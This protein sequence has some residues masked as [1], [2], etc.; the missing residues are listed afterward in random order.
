MHFSKPDYE[1][2]NCEA[3]FLPYKIGTKCPN[4][5]VSISDTD[6]EEYLD[7]IKGIAESMKVHKLGHGTYFPGAWSILSMMDHIQSIIF[8]LF[9]TLEHEKAKNEEEFLIDLL[10][11][12]FE[13]DGREYLKDHIKSITKEIFIIYK[14]KE[15]LKSEYVEQKNTDPV[16]ETKIEKFKKGWH[17]FCHKNET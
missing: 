13:W 9:D 1:C 14:S 11:N 12:K 10:E 4:C 7:S 5:N 2:P 17:K 3:I 16:S 15:F 6:C 8:R